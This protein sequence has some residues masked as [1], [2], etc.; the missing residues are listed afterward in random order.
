MITP[1][2]L[3]DNLQLIKAIPP[4]GRILVEIKLCHQDIA[5]RTKVKLLIFVFIHTII[6]KLY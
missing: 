6:K 4:R 5:G 2:L 1:T 3:G